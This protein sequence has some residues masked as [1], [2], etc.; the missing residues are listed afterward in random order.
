MYELSGTASAITRP[1]M[2]MIT[3]KAPAGLM[4]SPLIFV[5]G[6]PET[7]ESTPFPALGPQVLAACIV[8]AGE[9]LYALLRDTPL[10]SLMCPETTA[11]TCEKVTWS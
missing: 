10:A 9:Q 2:G 7:C 1:F 6:F 8:P 11:P 5:V 3:T 4:A